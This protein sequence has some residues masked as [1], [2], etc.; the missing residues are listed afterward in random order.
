[1]MIVMLSREF[2]VP[3]TLKLYEYPAS[4]KSFALPKRWMEETE[5]VKI[6]DERLGTKPPSDKIFNKKRE[7]DLLYIVADESKNGDI[8][9]WYL[10]YNPDL[11]VEIIS[12]N[13]GLKPYYPFGDEP[14]DEDIFRMIR[15]KLEKNH[16]DIQ[17]KKLLVSEDETDDALVILTFDVPCYLR[18]VIDDA[19]E[20]LMTAYPIREVAN[21]ITK[22]SRREVNVLELAGNRKTVPS[23]EVI[24]RIERVLYEEILKR[25]DEPCYFV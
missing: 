9:V 8:R 11:I 10:L 4:A 15:D 2:Y 18:M 1:M 5:L 16:G 17:F 12:Q 13:L 3:G 22:N 14:S 24:E 25:L 21:V 7:I 19:V 6:Y 23:I 20:V